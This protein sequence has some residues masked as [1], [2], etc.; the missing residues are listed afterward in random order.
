[1]TSDLVRDYLKAIG[2]TPLL[3]SADEQV[4]ACQIQEMLSLSEV[5]APERTPQQKQQI[6]QGELARQRMIQANL[7][8][9]VSIAKRYVNRGVDI[10]DLI[11]EGS[12]GLS[13]AT[14]KFDPDRG[15][16]FSTYAYWWIRQAITRA[17]AEQSR[18]I[19]LPIHVTERL[20]QFKKVQRQLTQTLGRQP[21]RSELA[22]ALEM[23]VEQLEDLL[24]QTRKTTSLDRLVGDDETPL[25]E[26]I[27]D[28][29]LG[30]ED[31]VEL[32]LISQEVH[33]LMNCLTTQERFAISAKYGLETGDTR[34]RKTIG[35]MLGGVSEQRVRQIEKS[36]MRKLRSAAIKHHPVPQP[37][38]PSPNRSNLRRYFSPSSSRSIS[39]PISQAS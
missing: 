13:R 31:Q 21:R 11:Q 39:L 8:L 37:A 27:A 1:M 10:M 17:I 36:G 6:R 7:R 25:S 38:S 20:N 3:T 9:V 12:L 30:P 26:M 15:Y 22:L 23:D 29:H 16:K 33:T 4:L 28:S 18:A 32:E 5:P 19:R 2:K 24:A 14:E 34:S 35:Q